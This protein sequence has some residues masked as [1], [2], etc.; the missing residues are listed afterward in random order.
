MTVNV[1]NAVRLLALVLSVLVYPSAHAN[2][3]FQSWNAVALA[4]PVKESSPWQYWFDGHYRLQDNASELGVF[5]IRPAIGYKINT[6]TTFWLGYARIGIDGEP[7]NTYEDRIWQQATFSMGALFGGSLSGRTR[8]EQRF[9]DEV[10]SDTGHRLR[11]FVRWAKP[12][13]E[14]WSMVVWDELFVGLNDSDWGQRSGFDQNR[15]YVG[16]AYHLNKKWRVE[17]G[18]MNNFINIP[19]EDRPSQVNH[20]LSLTFFG[21]L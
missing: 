17:L 9:R 16:P 12:I 5:I 3:D 13:N 11:Q 15:L 18:Y 8:L 20:N 7:S 4:G 1:K 10:A 19:G 6:K 14:K 2:S 21:S